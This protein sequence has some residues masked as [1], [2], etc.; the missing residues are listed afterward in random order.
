MCFFIYSAASIIS[1][2]HYDISISTA[3]ME[4]TVSE[5]HLDSRAYPIA[6]FT[7]LEHFLNSRTHQVASVA[8]LVQSFNSGAQPTV[9]EHAVPLTPIYPLA[10]GMYIRRHSI[11]LL[12]L[13]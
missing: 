13:Q 8:T 2:I 1:A 7:M 11:C 4:P 9:T 12:Y 3:F 5:H 10:I 6:S